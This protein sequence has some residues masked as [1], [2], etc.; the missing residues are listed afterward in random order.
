VVEDPGHNI[1]RAVAAL[2]YSRKFGKPWNK[3][4]ETV[5]NKQSFGSTHLVEYCGL[6]AKLGGIAMRDDKKTEAL[7]KGGKTLGYYQTGIDVDKQPNHDDG[8]IEMGLFCE[9]VLC[10]AQRACAAVTACA[11]CAVRCALCALRAA[12]CALRVK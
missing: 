2:S 5:Y 8:T 12:R 11:R 9:K 10:C 7:E 6:A 3:K 4:L 1:F